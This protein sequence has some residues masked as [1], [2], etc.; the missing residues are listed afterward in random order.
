MCLFPGQVS[1]GVR[2]ARKAVPPARSFLR[3]LGEPLSGDYPASLLNGVRKLICVDG[4][5]GLDR[6]VRMVVANLAFMGGG[7]YSSLDEYDGAL[8]V[9]RAWRTERCVLHEQ[10]VYADQ[11]FGAQK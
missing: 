1:K 9:L 6:D 7:F 3:V 11:N 4:V 2:R 8:D 10:R 5:P